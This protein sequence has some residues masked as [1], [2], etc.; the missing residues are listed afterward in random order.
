LYSI[1]I[2]T[3][4]RLQSEVKRQDRIPLRPDKVVKPTVL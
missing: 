3:L 1:S 4:A 2:A